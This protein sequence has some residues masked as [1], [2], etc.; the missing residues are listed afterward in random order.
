M[1]EKTCIDYHV[2]EFK[3]ESDPGVSNDWD[4]RASRPPFSILA[5]FIDSSHTP[6]RPSLSKYILDRVNELKSPE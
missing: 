2:E 6:F 4:E 3:D 5:F 1:R